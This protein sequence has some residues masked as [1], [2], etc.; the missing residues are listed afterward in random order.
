MK[1]RLW[2]VLSLIAAALS[3]MYVHRVLDP[4]KYTVNVRQGTMRALMGDLYSPWL[5]AHELLVYGINPYSPQVTE[6]IQLEFYGHPIQQSYNAPRV[7][8]EQRFA[9]P[10]YVVLLLAPAAHLPFAEVQQW[11]PFVL[12]ALIA[13]SILVWMRM[14]GWR[15][16]ALLQVSVMVFMLASPQIVQGLRLRQL[17]MLVAALLALAC[18]CVFKRH[19]FLAGLLLAL[20]TI[21][22]QM[23][24][25]VGLWFLLWT[26]ADWGARWPLAAGFLTTLL[27]LIGVGEYFLPGWLRDFLIGLNAYRKYSP[28]MQS[29]TELTLGN[30]AGRICS[31]LA[32]LALLV[33]A[34]RYR[35]VKPDSVEFTRVLAAFLTLSVLLLPMMSLFNQVLLVFPV[36]MVISAWSSLSSFGRSAF[37][38]L[39]AWPS[40]F[41]FCFLIKSPNVNSTGLLPLLPDA[42]AVI[43]P[44]LILVLLIMASKQK[45]TLC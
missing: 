22:P 39:V 38:I 15:I 16:S 10:V 6:K 37:A 24:V 30:T 2:F 27:V 32:I 41:S 7:L 44:F 29:L 42:A 45:Q 18:W 11:A 13:I 9:Y 3:W 36:L 12:G 4:W 34:G 5:G 35:R 17:G 31:T 14:L 25:L 19:L 23:I 33:W 8:D 21:K 40:F 1:T 28:A 43:F 20:C 26:I